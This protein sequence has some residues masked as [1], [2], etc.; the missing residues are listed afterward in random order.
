LELTRKGELDAQMAANTVKPYDPKI[1]YSSDLTR[2]MQT[3][4]IISAALGNMP[5]EV[6]YELRTAD[7]GTLTGLTEAEAMPM[8]ERW[9]MSTWIDAPSG[10]SYDRFVSRLYPFID[11]QLQFMRDVP[12][13]RPVLMATHGRIFAALDSLYNFRPPIDGRMAM[14]GGVAILKEKSDGR[15][16]MEFLGPTESVIK[17]V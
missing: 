6:Y 1:I 10:E 14:P 12:Q 4:N 17:D 7:M 2:D 11:K 16:V 5:T 13:I 9:Y 15:M 3:A 8:V